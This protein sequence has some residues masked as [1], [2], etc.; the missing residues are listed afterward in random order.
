[1]DAFWSELDFFFF[2][3]PLCSRK[4]LDRITFFIFALEQKPWIWPEFS[5]F[6]FFHLICIMIQFDL[7]KLDVKTISSQTD[8]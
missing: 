7:E 1:M 3:Q 5:K 8:S 2:K 6:L 4:W